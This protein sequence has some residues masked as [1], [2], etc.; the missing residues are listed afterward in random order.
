MMHMNSAYCGCKASSFPWLALWLGTDFLAFGK[1]IN[2]I[3]RNDTVLNKF[4]YQ[5]C[6]WGF[7]RMTVNMEHDQED[8]IF[9]LWLMITI[10]LWVRLLPNLLKVL[11]CPN[12]S[13]RFDHNM[14]VKVGILMNL[15]HAV[16]MLSSYLSHFLDWSL[17]G[18]NGKFL[19]WIT[20]PIEINICSNNLKSVLGQSSAFFFFFSSCLSLAGLV[21]L[22]FCACLDR[23]RVIKDTKATAW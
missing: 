19:W 9:M 2:N 21:P 4:W 8:W 11:N 12:F 18:G 3:W 15:Y 20:A 5:Q 6:S 10:V 17:G 13:I 16:D 14:T 22:C 1:Y 23:E 7:L